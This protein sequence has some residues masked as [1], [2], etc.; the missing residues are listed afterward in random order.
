M[1][2]NKTYHLYLLIGQSNM[3]GRGELGPHDIETHHRV[4]ALDRTNQW[5]PAADPIHFDKPIA[6]VGPGLCFGKTM[7]DRD[8]SVYIGLIPCAV[9]GSP[10]STWR[11]GG[12][13]K[14]TDSYP[15]DDAI[16][17]TQVAQKSGVLKGI[18][19]H[20]GES[21]SN[22]RDADRYP[23]RLDALIARLRSQLNAPGVPFV[24]ATLGDFVVSRNPWAQI[25]NDALLALPQRVQQT[26]CV[27]TAGLEHIGDDLHFNGASARE[28][29]RRYAKAMAELLRKGEEK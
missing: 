2:L 22:E 1:A 9:G 8:S 13:W 18:L 7:A 19:W 14:Q 25:V 28:L 10:I 11:P 29:G 17:R 16:V 21:D 5:T 12:Y 24:A 26:A 20:Q 4:F 15:Y 27:E 3:A 6:A 23:D